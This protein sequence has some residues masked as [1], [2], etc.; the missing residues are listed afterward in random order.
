[1]RVEVEEKVIPTSSLKIEGRGTFIGAKERWLVKLVGDYSPGTEAPPRSK[2]GGSQDD[3]RRRETARGATE[4][5]KHF[6]VIERK[7]RDDLFEYFLPTGI[8]RPFESQRG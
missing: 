4:K 6:R 5:N 1:M 2:R 8:R 3:V 7:V